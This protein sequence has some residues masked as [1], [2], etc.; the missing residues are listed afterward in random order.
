MNSK[1]SSDWLPNYIKATRLVL[2]IFKMADTFR[3]SHVY[4]QY[5]I[6]H[7][8]SVLNTKSSPFYH[9]RRVISSLKTLPCIR[10][11]MFVCTCIGFISNNLYHHIAHNVPS[12]QGSSL[13]TVLP[14]TLPLYYDLSNVVSNQ[15]SVKFHIQI[16]LR[17]SLK[18]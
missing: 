3:T 10:T 17:Y 9:N 13:M 18:V 4:F 1:V 14:T 11:H 2:E 15:I 16:G 7:V 6:I 8:F 5:R 12:P